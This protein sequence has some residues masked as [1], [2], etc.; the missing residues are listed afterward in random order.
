[1]FKNSLTGVLK[2]NKSMRMKTRVLGYLKMWSDPTIAHFHSSNWFMVVPCFGREKTAETA[3]FVK[4]LTKIV[5]LV[6]WP[7]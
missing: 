3:K 6:R 4:M 2:T 7:K 5:G 1:M